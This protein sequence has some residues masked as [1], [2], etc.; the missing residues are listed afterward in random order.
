VVCLHW[1]GA[2]PC[3]GCGGVPSLGA[4]LFF[5]PLVNNNIALPAG[6]TRMSLQTPG[7]PRRLGPPRPSHTLAS[8]ASS[9]NLSLAQSQAVARKASLNAL[10]GKPTTPTS[11]MGTDGRDLEVGDLVDVPGAMTGVVRFIGSVHGK[12]GVFAGV[13]LSRQ[14]ASRGKND[15]DVDGYVNCAINSACMLTGTQHTLLCHHRPRLRHILA[16]PPR[17]EA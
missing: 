8:V 16:R 11:K 10:V 1:G 9:P 5:G 14:Y 6:Y 15:G 7:T 12:P 17:E 3:D 2:A 13:E 4:A